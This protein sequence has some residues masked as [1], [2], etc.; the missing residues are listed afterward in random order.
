MSINDHERVNCQ[1][2]NKKSNPR[3]EKNAEAHDR[4]RDTAVLPDGSITGAHPKDPADTILLRDGERWYLSETPS[5][6]RAPASISLGLV[7]ALEKAIR[8]LATINASSA[9]LALPEITKAS[10]VT[11][12]HCH[13]I[14]KTFV[15]LDWLAYDDRLKIYRLQTGILRD[16]S[17]I[18]STTNQL[19]LVRPI[20]DRLARKIGIPVVLS[21]PLVDGS[22]LVVDKFSAPHVVEVSFPIGFRAPKDA[23]AQ[24]RANLAWRNPEEIDRQLRE[25]Q[26]KRYT[27]RSPLDRETLR[28]EIFATRQRGYARNVGE[29]T[30]GLM[31][32]ALPIF[33]REGLPFLIFNCASLMPIMQQQEAK[34]STA[35]LKAAREIHDALGSLVP[36]DFL[37]GLT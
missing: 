31:A 12:S 13:A 20:L 33:D 22:F 28:K 35:M 24:M 34:V 19:S 21:Q 37:R 9:G 8:I 7:P 4:V 25:W 6:H 14:L 16:T 32:L 17:S 29:F 11:R 5:T 36:S 2:R 27:D 30:E 10:G 15:A 3:N 26:P 1:V 23:A 18:L